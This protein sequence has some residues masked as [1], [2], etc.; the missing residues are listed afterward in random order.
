MLY[1][2]VK[3]FLATL[4]NPAFCFYMSCCKYM[5]LSYHTPSPPVTFAIPIIYSQLFI[6]QH[7]HL[8]ICIL[9][10]GLFL[11]KSNVIFDKLLHH[12]ICTNFVAKDLIIKF[13]ETS[14]A[15]YKL[16]TFNINRPNRL[17]IYT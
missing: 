7:A 10:G 4:R 3:A 9:L 1:F 13:V 15:E 14:L 11:M 17:Y 8:H 5:V 2:D 6:R 12:V 16:A